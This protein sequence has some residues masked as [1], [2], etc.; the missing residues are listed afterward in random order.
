MSQQGLIVDERRT[1]RRYKV[2]FR[3]HVKRE[4]SPAVEGELADL[5][6]GG[7]FV[8]SHEYLN[9]GDLVELRIEFPG[10]DNLTI[11][12]NVVFWIGETG[13]G[14]RFGAFSQGGAR[15]KLLDLLSANP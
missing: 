5:S 1:D 4:A 7:C 8:T 9:E 15:E 11:W 13:F 6:A 2:S 14:V 10:N 12:G 3:V